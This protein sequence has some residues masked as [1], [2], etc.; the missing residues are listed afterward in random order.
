[1]LFTQSN[2]HNP[3]AS[4]TLYTNTKTPVDTNKDIQYTHNT[5]VSGTGY[6]LPINASIL[7]IS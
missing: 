1:M 2:L 4:N 7:S 3:I 6:R 5:I